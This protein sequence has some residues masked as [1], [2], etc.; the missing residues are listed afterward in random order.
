MSAETL[1]G[2]VEN[3]EREEPL[4]QGDFAILKDRADSHSEGLGALIALV[5]AGAR[6]LSSKL[7]D[8]VQGATTRA[9]RAMRPVQCL[10]VLTG[11]V[12][13]AVNGVG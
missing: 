12:R 3:T 6:G 11:L 9:D 8:A 4:V 13:I 5:N 2:A 7:R 10:K 1:L